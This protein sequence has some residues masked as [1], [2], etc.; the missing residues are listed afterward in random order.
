MSSAERLPALDGLRAT[1][2][3]LVLACHMLPLGPKV[4]QLNGAAGAMG[5]SLFFALSG[6]LIIS[7]LKN[8]ADVPEFL[9]RRLTSIRAT[10]VCIY[11]LCV[12]ITVL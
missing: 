2:I 12:R 10:C 4:L 7:V 11:V 5:M 8:N 1:S 6:F 3:L 9:I